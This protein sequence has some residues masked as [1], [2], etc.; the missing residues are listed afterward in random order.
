MPTLAAASSAIT[1]RAAMA[2]DGAPS[3]GTR[4]ERLPLG[5][6]PGLHETALIGFV[7]LVLAGLAQR[8]G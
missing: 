5:F 4:T 2:D 7:L 1:V 8:R 3:R 6:L